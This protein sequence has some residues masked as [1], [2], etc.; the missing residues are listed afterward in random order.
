MRGA[1]VLVHNFYCICTRIGAMID[2][3]IEA[4]LNYNRKKIL[5]V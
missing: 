1:S 3:D 4:F 5:E 2:K